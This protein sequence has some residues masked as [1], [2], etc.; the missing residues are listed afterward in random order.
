MSDPNLKIDPSALYKAGDELDSP[1]NA[2]RRAKENFVSAMSG[3]KPWAWGDDE[4]GRAFA[5][6]EFGYLISSAN[7]QEGIDNLT[8]GLTG[9]SDLVRQMSNNFVNTEY[10]NTQ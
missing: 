8:T 6:G 4:I 9:T 10:A 2:L 5:E 3:I 1:V 7:I